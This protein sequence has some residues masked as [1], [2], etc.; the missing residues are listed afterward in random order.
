M[1]AKS[2]A[3]EKN[4]EDGIAAKH[5]VSVPPGMWSGL[6]FRH[7]LNHFNLLISVHYTMCCLTCVSCALS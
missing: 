5:E 3:T 7:V 1:D 6:L 4:K 2:H